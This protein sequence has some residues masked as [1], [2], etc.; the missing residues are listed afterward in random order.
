MKLL[1]FSPYFYPY[2]SGIT[3]YPYT[4]FQELVKENLVTVLTFPHKKNLRSYEV[5]RSIHIHRMP[6]LF[7]VS[8]GFISPQSL[9]YFLR[10]VRKNDVI[11]LNIPNFEGLL[12][13][14][15]AKLFN[16]KILCIF[17]CQ[18]HME[19]SPL[20]QIISFFLQISVSVQLRLADRITVYTKDYAQAVGLW[21]LYK[22]KISTILPPVRRPEID[23]STYKEH[24]KAKKK[25]V[26][27]G[28]A[29]RVSREKG[30]ENLVKATS[31]LDLRAK[32]KVRL[33]FAGP[34]G[35]DV[36]GELEYYHRIKRLLNKYKIPHLFIGNQRDGNLG[37]FYAAIDTL[38]LPS[39]NRTEAF[40][41]VQAEAM[42]CGTP[43]VCSNLP[44]VRMPITLTGMGQTV[45][46]NNVSELATTIREILSRPSRYSS[47]S[48]VKHAQE[49]F[50]LKGVIHAYQDELL[51]LKSR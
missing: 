29:G 27:I 16:K 50:A 39:I 46:I 37:A 8:K 17:H 15:L 9:G 51:Y 13:A 26:W 4:L 43:V 24:M 23:E 7:K 49:L 5:R 35:A 18:V 38:V 1:F 34:Y 42:M 25:E 19:T 44:G 48:K 6:Y 10:E 2:T 11:I 28:F 30:L 20:E 47:K 21:K 31:Q 3:T 33:I 36:A 22:K 45:K 32:K 14:I 12:L 40:G 41:M